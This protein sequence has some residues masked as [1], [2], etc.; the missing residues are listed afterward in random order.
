MSDLKTLLAAEEAGRTDHHWLVRDVRVHG[1]PA[2][3]DVAASAFPDGFRR[4]SHRTEQTFMTLDVRRDNR[5]RRR[6]SGTF[7]VDAKAAVSRPSA[8]A[9]RDDVTRLPFPRFTTASEGHPH[10]RENRS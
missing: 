9:V 1:Q 3:L 5:D 4:P 10:E 6:P 7:S 2:H 8:M